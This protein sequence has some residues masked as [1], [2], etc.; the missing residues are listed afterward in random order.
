MLAVAC[1]SRIPQEIE[2]LQRPEYRYSSEPLQLGCGC[3]CCKNYTKAYLYHLFD[4]KE[5]NA[6]ILLAVHNAYTFDQM[7]V[8]LQKCKSIEY[9]AWLLES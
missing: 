9:I 1:E 8:A 7:F 4:V 5:M 2:I 3:Y 6:N